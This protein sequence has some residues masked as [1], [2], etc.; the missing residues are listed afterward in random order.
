MLTIKSKSATATFKQQAAEITGFKKNGSD[1]EYMWQ[2]D[3]AFWAGRNPI[4]F[5][6][7]GNT[8]SKDYVIDGKTYAMGNHGL[9]RHMNFD[10]L[11][12]SEDA[13]SLTVTDNEDT[14]KQY[15]FK[16]RL[17]VYYQLVDTRLSI[18]YKIDN[19]GATAMPFVF[20][21]HPAFNVPLAEGEFSDYRLVFETEE[22]P[23]QIVEDDREIVVGPFKELKLDYETFDRYPTLVYR[24][25]KSSYV[26][27]TNYK[28]GL[29]VGIAGY[30]YL[31][32]WCGKRAPFLCVEPWYGTGDEK[33][34]QWK[35]TERPGTNNLAAG[36]SFYTEYYIELL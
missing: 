12:T 3:P 18:K 1:I 29:Q 4:L 5:P 30:P 6:I 33:P 22:Q 8:Y 17:S 26:Q 19:V 25:L 13:L 9:A 28:E 15:P 24:N 23:F 34:N 14:L 32:F 16:F 20:G 21:L 7:V 31:A 11:E 35:F 36:E 27:L 2:G 10:V